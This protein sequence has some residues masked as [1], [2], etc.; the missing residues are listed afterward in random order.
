MRRIADSRSCG[1][2]GIQRA[3]V[4]VKRVIELWDLS[5]RYW[6]RLLAMVA[7]VQ[8]KEASSTWDPFAIIA[9]QRLTLT[10]GR[11]RRMV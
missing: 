4:I 8:P 9:G 1:L 2:I 7:P 11:C 3:P 10:A 5:K 6:D